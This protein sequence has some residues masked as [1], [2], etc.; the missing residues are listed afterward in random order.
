MRV[1]WSFFS[2]IIVLVACTRDD[3]PGVIIPEEILEEGIRLT[4]TY[5]Y[6]VLGSP[7]EIEL[8][9]EL[10]NADLQR[11]PNPEYSILVNE[12]DMG[13]LSTFNP[14][15]AEIFVLN[16]VS[17]DYVSED[18]YITIREPIEYEPVEFQVIFHVAATSWVGSTTGG[19]LLDQ[20]DEQMAI[21]DRVFGTPSH[22]TPNS[23]VPNFSFKLATHDPTGVPL[24]DA[25][26][27][28]I[29]LPSADHT[30]NY[31]E[32]LWNDYW[33]PEFYINIWVG[34]TEGR[35][36]Y[37]S[38]PR[39]K[40]GAQTINGLGGCR[41]SEPVELTGIVLNIH[42]VAS[43]HDML[44]HEM[45]H[46]FG[47]RHVFGEDECAVFND[48]CPDTHTYDLSGYEDN[49]TGRIRNSCEGIEYMSFNI[50]D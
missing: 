12:V 29:T 5:D 19:E 50:M 25:G 48:F 15:S 22:G 8:L 13:P 40:C 47:L 1:N 28:R 18:L 36:S 14:S 45:G 16:A 37:G 11:V 20:I 33:D 44:P 24:V 4:A 27:N 42:S 32:W 30:V 10:V 21:L 49:P 43:G 26:I 41:S 23:Y 6:G 9:V 34:P 7:T 3:I 46:F 17:G 31:E 2:L 38:Y 39:L 35:Y